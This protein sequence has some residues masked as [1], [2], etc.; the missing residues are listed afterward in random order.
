M[1]NAVQ[2]YWIWESS[3]PPVASNNIQ[4]QC[5]FV[6]HIHVSV[7]D[8]YTC[9][10]FTGTCMLGYILPFVAGA[11]LR[12]PSHYFEYFAALLQVGTMRSTS[13]CE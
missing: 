1:L 10:R 4:G 13:G 11:T 7:A 6:M 3:A 9:I 12:P 2:P 5:T 8:L